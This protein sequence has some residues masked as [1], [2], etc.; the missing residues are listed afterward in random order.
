MENAMKR[1]KTRSAAVRRDPDLRGAEAGVNEGQPSLVLTGS[2]S[3]GDVSFI[4]G[5]RHR[6]TG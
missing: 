3:D 4:N 2:G 1:W 6:E 5:E